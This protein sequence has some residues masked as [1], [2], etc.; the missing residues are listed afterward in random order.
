[1]EPYIHDRTGNWLQA[2]TIDDQAS[3]QLANLATF[4]VHRSQRRPNM[5]REIRVPKTAYRKVVGHPKAALQ[6]FDDHALRKLV[7]TTVD[8]FEL[9]ILSQQFDKGMAP[10]LH[11]ARST[12]NGNREVAP[13]GGKETLAPH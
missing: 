13:D 12:D 7:R 4:D 5:G 11:T 2:A 10:Q 9:R 1:M 6:G 3:C 8:G